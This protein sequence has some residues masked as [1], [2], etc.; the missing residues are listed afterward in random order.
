MFSIQN[1][2]ILVSG[3]AKGNGKVLADGFVKKGAIVIY[4]DRLSKVKKNHLIDKTGRSIS[5]KIDLTY[6]KDLTLL[7]NKLL[8]FNKIDALVNNAG[9]SLPEDNLSYN[10]N[11]NKTLNTNLSSIYNLTKLVTRLMVAQKAGSIVNITSLSSK[12]GFKG[13]PSYH[14]SK[15]GLKQ[16]TKSF[17]ADYGQYNIRF[18]NICPGYIKTDMTIKSFKD[19]KKRNIIKSRTMLKR[20]GESKDLL[21]PSIFLISDASSYITGSTI[22]VD[23]GFTSFGF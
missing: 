12:M 3:S 5:V 8:K 4:L 16:L 6:K 20:W 9:V 15:G 21:G 14:A 17:A 13:N 7:N 1:K 11:W 19:S 2:V 18:N 10:N 22:Y 23:G